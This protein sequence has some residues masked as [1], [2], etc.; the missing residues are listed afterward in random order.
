MADLSDMWRSLLGQAAAI[1]P[2][3]LCLAVAVL[4]L[5]GVPV[6]PLLIALGITAGPVRGTILA[7]MGLAINIAL[8]YHVARGWPRKVILHWLTRRGYQLPQV[9]TR[10][11]IR[12]ILMSRL[13]PGLPLAGQNYLL[14]IAGVRFWPYFLCSVPVQGLYALG[15]VLLGGSLVDSAVW[16]IGTAVGALICV[17]LGL[18]W[19]RRYL[20]ARN[21][22]NST[23]KLLP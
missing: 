2:G 13:I 11:E 20:Q 8:G 6:S 3:L 4:P 16:K 1:P 21:L 9:K 18:S 12:L 22:A 23:P 15:F 14:G 10:D 19:I 5:I 17:G 7:I